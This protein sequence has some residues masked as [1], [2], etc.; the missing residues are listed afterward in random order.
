MPYE[1]HFDPKKKWDQQFLV[2]RDHI[3]P[4]IAKNFDLRSNMN[5]LEVGCGEGGVLKAFC[6]KGHTGYG[7]DLAAHRIE[8]ARKLLSEEVEQSKAFFYSADVYNTKVY[9]HLTGAID[10]LILKDAIE[11]IPDQGKILHVLRNFL[12]P[13]GVMFVAFPPWF[14]P[15]GGHQQLAGSFLKI[16][17]W[18]HLL[19][20]AIYK[21]ILKAAG[22]KQ[23]QIDVLLEIYNTRIT[24]RQFEKMSRHA[25]WEIVQRQ[26]YLFNPIYEYKFGLKGRKQFPMLAAMPV[27]RD[28]VSTGVYYLLKPM[29]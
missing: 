18:F 27:F 16:T 14:N 22:E 25:K 7:V 21:R 8:N 1:H 11:H 2:T 29:A 24:V 10:V 6:E 5:V 4:F 12:K 15:F 19:P 26:F 28:F 9:E 17:P 20:K 23:S 3:I 13:G